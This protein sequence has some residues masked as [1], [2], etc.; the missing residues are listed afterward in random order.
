[1]T[2]SRVH[3]SYPTVFP[4]TTLFR[5][6]PGDVEF[7]RAAV[8]RAETDGDEREGIDVDEPVDLEDERAERNEPVRNADD[9]DAA[10]HEVDR[11]STRLNSSHRCTSYA[12]FCFKIER[13]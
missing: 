13:L 12:A 7:E 10:R 2:F 11:K 6:R 8:Q 3:P 5:A 9:A 4:Y 1:M